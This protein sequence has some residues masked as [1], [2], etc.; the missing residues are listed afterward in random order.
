VTDE[1]ETAQASTIHAR[2]IAVFRR[3]SELWDAAH[4]KDDSPELTSSSGF[5]AVEL[6]PHRN[7]A[8]DSEPYLP[9]EHGTTRD[10]A[11]CQRIACGTRH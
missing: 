6:V 8:P 11:R 3:T 1:E 7:P 5:K 9:I 10:W 4:E 2:V